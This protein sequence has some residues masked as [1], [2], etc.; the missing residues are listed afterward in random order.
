QAPD[1]FILRALAHH[2]GIQYN[3]VGVVDAGSLLV[4]Q[5]RKR[6]RQPAGVRGVHLTAFSPDVVSHS[7]LLYRLYKI[8][9]LKDVIIFLS[10]TA[11]DSYKECHGIHKNGL[12]TMCC[13]KS[14]RP[15]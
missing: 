13:S 8:S 9:V 5:V 7:C 2:A 15:L 12:Q 6:T 11:I 1:S 10:V 3:H 4:T 14:S